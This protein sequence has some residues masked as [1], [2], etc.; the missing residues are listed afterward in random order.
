MA[1]GILVLVEHQG[2][3]PKKTTLELVAKAKELGIGPVSAAVIGADGAGMAEVLGAHG[4][5]KVYVAQG[6]GLEQY[7]AGRY[8]AALASIA[9]TA[10]PVSILGTASPNGKDLMPRVAARLGTVMAADCTDLGAAGG[11]LSATRPMYAGKA[12]S[13]VEIPTATPQVFSMR[14]N[15]FTTSASGGG[16]A[17]VESLAVEFKAGDSRAKVLEIKAGSSAKK[18]LTEA[19]RIVS[20][21]RSIKSAE[22]FSVIE[23]VAEVLGAAVGASR[24]A[25]DAGYA[26]HDMQVGQTG[27]TVNPQLYIAFGISGAIQHLAGMRTSK[28]IVAVNTDPEAP[29]FGVADY[30][31]HAD[32]FEFAPVLAEE[33][34]KVL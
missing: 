29:I 4:A 6:D 15:S 11:R 21:G 19:E 32:L 10:D 34:K 18:D 5:D 12:L 17:S 22:N 24:A 8:A 7:T 31:V 28:V 20:A 14:P 2:G 1:T 27:K 9:K 23:P 30:G 13:K 16:A 33:L 25:V 3:A 26:P